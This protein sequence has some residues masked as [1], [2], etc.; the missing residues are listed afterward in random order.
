[1]KKAIII[2]VLWVLI[3]WYSRYRKQDMSISTIGTTVY[4]QGRDK[5]ATLKQKIAWTAILMS[6]QEEK[7]TATNISLLRN[8]ML[9]EVNKQRTNNGV[10]WVKANTRLQTIAQTYAEY[11]ASTDD[12]AHITKKW[13]TPADRAIRGGYEYQKIAENLAYGQF[14][15]EKVMTDRMNSEWHKKN[16]L[17]DLYEEIGIGYA[18]WYRVQVFGTQMKK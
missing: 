18:S 5:L 11:L 8:Q 1:M 9:T 13:E 15:V 6:S 2:I 7:I 17:S 12:F 14:T 3:Y 4:Q 16:I 10:M